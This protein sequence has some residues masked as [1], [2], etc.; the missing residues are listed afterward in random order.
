MAVLT[1]DEAAENRGDEKNC[2]PHGIQEVKES[3]EEAGPSIPCRGMP[4]M[5]C[6]VPLDPTPQNSPNH[7]KSAMLGPEHLSGRPL[8]VIP[9]PDW[10]RELCTVGRKL[11]SHLAV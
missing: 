1:Y 3:E 7:S 4:P 2:V 11:D 5:T 6:A 10:S 9:D 8:A